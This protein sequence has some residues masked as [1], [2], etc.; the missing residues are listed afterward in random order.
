MY[1][2][3]EKLLGIS[4]Y[5]SIFPL[6]SILFGNI[7]HLN[8]L[9]M[10]SGYWFYPNALKQE[11]WLSNKFQILNKHIFIGTFTVSVKFTKIQLSAPNPLLLEYEA[12]IY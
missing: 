9:E 10:S 5:G 8:L 3:G 4:K 7:Q 2:H 11:I 1:V 12:E 6:S